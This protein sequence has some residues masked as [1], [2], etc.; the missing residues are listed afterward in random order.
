M[1]EDIIRLLELNNSTRQGILIEGP[2][3]EYVSK[4]YTKS[5]ILPFIREGVLEGFI[6]FY[7]NDYE[8]KKAFLSMI[9]VA[10]DF[11][12]KGIGKLLLKTS[13]EYLR[14]QEFKSYSLE[15]LKNNIVAIEFYKKFGFV[16]REDKGQF[17]LMELILL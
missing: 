5:T 4:I 6:S 11:Q 13:L 2:I 16:V 17:W 14:K 8:R 15:V 3:E 1:K 7:C 9:L 12:S 10:N